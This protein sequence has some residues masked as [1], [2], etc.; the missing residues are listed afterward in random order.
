MVA[1]GSGKWLVYLT[2]DCTK[3]WLKTC[4]PSGQTPPSEPPE[5]ASGVITLPK[6]A[7]ACVC[8]CVPM[9]SRVGGERTDGARVVGELVAQGVKRT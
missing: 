5:G 8:A 4:P 9:L 7:Y 1:A 2:R 3:G 6:G